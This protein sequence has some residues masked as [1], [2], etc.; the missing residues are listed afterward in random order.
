MR[1]KVSIDHG[2]IKTVQTD[3]NKNLMVKSTTQ[4]EKKREALGALKNCLHHHAF[5][6]DNRSLKDVHKGDV[7]SKEERD[8]GGGEKRGKPL[9]CG[10]CDELGFSLG[11]G[12][13]T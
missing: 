3:W 9:E 11:D 13:Y 1:F 8:G 10:A 5:I 2:S 4:Y 7:R 12:R 6:I